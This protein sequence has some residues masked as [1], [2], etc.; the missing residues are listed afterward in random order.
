[1]RAL[2]AGKLWSNSSVALRNSSSAAMSADRL[3]RDS[4]P[5]N[6]KP[7]SD[8]PPSSVVGRSNSAGMSKISKLTDSE[9]WSS[10]QP[11][12][13]VLQSNSAPSIASTRR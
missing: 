1:M 6:G 13:G 10:K 8:A 5:P 3:S 12:G 9:P 7:P 11:S 2:P 4:A